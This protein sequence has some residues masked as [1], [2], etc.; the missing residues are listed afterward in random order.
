MPTLTANAGQFS[1]AVEVSDRARLVAVN[2]YVQYTQDS[3]VDVRNGVAAWTT[4][5]LGAVAGSMDTVAEMVVRLVASGNNARLDI[6]DPG[7][8]GIQPAGVLW[9][10]DAGELYGA[11]NVFLG[12]YEGGVTVVGTPS[13][14]QVI[15]WSG[16]QWEPD[17]DLQGGASGGY[18]FA[19]SAPWSLISSGS[20]NQTTALNSFLNDAAVGAAM[21]FPQGIIKAYGILFKPRMII[22]GLG[23][24]IS[25]N[26]GVDMLASTP[27]FAPDVASLGGGNIA[28]NP[29]YGWYHDVRVQGANTPGA[30]SSKYT[31]G[32]TANAFNRLNVSRMAVSNMGIGLDFRG[33]NYSSADQ[34][35]VTGCW[36]GMRIRNGPNYGGG[37]DSWFTNCRIIQNEG[38]FDSGPVGLGFLAS[39][40]ASNGTVPMN[41]IQLNNVHFNRHAT[42]HLA[43]VSMDKRRAR[44]LDVMLNGVAFEYAQNNAASN[45]TLW[46]NRDPLFYEYN[47]EDALDPFGPVVRNVIMPSSIYIETGRVRAP[48]AFWNDALAFVVVYLDGPFAEFEADT[49]SMGGNNN[50]NAYAIRANHV[51]ATAKVKNI[52]FGIHQNLIEWPETCAWGSSQRSTACAGA[53]VCRKVTAPEYVRWLNAGISSITPTW[54]ATSVTIATQGAVAD[55][56]QPINGQNVQQLT[57]SNTAWTYNVGLSGERIAVSNLLSSHPGTFTTCATS[58]L[59]RIESTDTVDTL[60]ALPMLE[61]ISGNGTTVTLTFREHHRRKTGDRICVYN[62]SIA[63]YNVSSAAVTV[64]GARTLTYAASGSGTPTDVG[65]P[66]GP[67]VLFRNFSTLTGAANVATMTCEFPHGY[68]A[69]ETFTVWVINATDTTYN[70]SGVTATATNFMSF[71]YPAT[72]VSGSETTATWYRRDPANIEL[73]WTMDGGKEGRQICAPNRWYRIFFTVAR[74]ANPYI[75]LWART[76]GVAFTLKTT[77]LACWQATSANLKT[78]LNLLNQFLNEGLWIE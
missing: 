22:D 45:E 28:Q 48:N 13:V 5:P 61:S 36:I 30:A 74:N 58:L 15:K 6:T 64:T 32:F 4:W 40:E 9:A 67:R 35:M 72:G 33:V 42:T 39:D 73:G 51:D 54:T 44:I 1:Q 23:T 27:V 34:C 53:P 20:L 37:T 2:G 16:S 69:G 29:N 38:R 19:G 21:L 3:I 49:I 66:A 63:G 55:S 71:T 14:G 68:R 65:F 50:G 18:S 76:P 7:G 70:V 62:S 75:A 25:P 11:G 8:N 12:S 17:I 41:N 31:M 26:D 10:T 46:S 59:V 56:S 60:N 52:D 78:E 24:V 57:F 43:L 47:D 77:R